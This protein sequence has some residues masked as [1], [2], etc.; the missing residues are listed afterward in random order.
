M[1]CCSSGMTMDSILTVQHADLFTRPKHLIEMQAAAMLVKLP[2]SLRIGYEH[3]FL[4]CW[5]KQF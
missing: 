5:T 2:V 3:N 4:I 1:H